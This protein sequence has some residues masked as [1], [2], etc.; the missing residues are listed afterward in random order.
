[1]AI[2]FSGQKLFTTTNNSVVLANQSRASVALKLRFE[3][4]GNPAHSNLSFLISRNFYS[5][6]WISLNGAG[7][8][9]GTVK[10]QFAWRTSATQVTRNVDLAVGVVHHLAMTFD[11]G[12]QVCWVNGKPQSFGSL[13]GTTQTSSSPFRIGGW[14][15]TPATDSIWT[16][17]DVAV[18]NDYVLTASDVAN[19]RDGVQSPADIG[20][21]ATMRGEWTLL[22]T[23]GQT[24]V[25]GQPGL[26]NAFG[27][28]SYDLTSITGSGTAV[29]ADPLVWTPAA[30]VKEARIGTSGKTLF[31]FFENTATGQGAIPQ[32]ANVA[33]AIVKNGGSLGQ[34][35]NPLCSGV[36]KYVMYTLPPGT[37]VAPGDVVTLNA[38]IDWVTTAV[39]AAGAVSGL[40]VVNNAGRSCFTS[41]TSGR[42]L[43]MGVNVEWY[44]T[45]HNALIPFAK[46]IAKRNNGFTGVA[47][48]DARGKPI[49]L[50]STWASALLYSN[51]VSTLDNG[52]DAT[53]YPGPTGLFAVGWDD[54][55]P[56]VPTTFGLASGDSSTTTVTERVD[57]ANPG[58]GGIG[59][60][61][62]FDVQRKAGSTVAVT[63]INLTVSNAA[64]A[65][66][67]DN[68]VVYGPGDFSYSSGKP[69]V[70]DRSN[71][72][73]LSSRFLDRI[74]RAGSLR[75]MANLLASADGSQIVEPEHVRELEDFSW[76]W[77]PSKSYTTIR[78]TR[79]DPF[80]VADT[81]YYYS[82]VAGGKYAATLADPIDATATTLNIS[83]AATAPVLVGLRLFVG[84][85]I[86]RVTGVSG[87]AVT[88]IRGAEGTT[89]APH[90]AGTI[91]VGYRL[92]MPA[93]NV[94]N[95]NGTF[96][97]FTTENPHGLSTGAKI[98]L[99]GS[100]WPI[101]NFTNGSATTAENP[102][103]KYSG[104][105]LVTGANTFVVR[106]GPYVT[107]EAT[108]TGVITLTPANN[109]SIIDI[110]GG[111]QIPY[112]FAALA[113]SQANVPNLFVNV[114]HM[115]T[116]DLVS[117]LARDVR[118]N[119]A[120]GKSLWVELSNEPWNFAI[121]NQYFKYISRSLY[122]GQDAMAYYVK[123]IDEVAAIFR[124]VFGEQGRSAEIK[125]LL[126]VQTVNTLG[127]S[128]LTWA[129]AQTPAIKIDGLAVAPYIEPTSNW[130][131]AASV[132]MFA[133]MDIEQ[134]LDLWI[135][136]QYYKTDNLGLTAFAAA[137][138]A[139]IDSYNTSTG[140]N[141]QL[142]SYEGGVQ[143]IYPSSVA[144]YKERDR[145]CVYHPN[146]YIIE[147]DWYYLLQSIGFKLFNVFAMS[148][149][150]YKGKYLW[151]LYHWMWQPYGRGD[152]SDGLPDNRLY[153]ATPGRP[154][155]KVATTN[156]D[157]QN[158]SVRGR[159][160]LD[161]NRSVPG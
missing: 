1:M 38:P 137:W 103:T 92:A 15:Y 73:A 46:N 61:R 139:A 83:D 82:R 158:V 157:L 161:W 93:L 148:H 133:N 124:S 153:Q 98:E 128:L 126:N 2:T 28:A 146:W 140:Y 7:S 29:Y 5:A 87:T 8:A 23:T 138:N 6:A 25:A 48:R 110:P 34:A 122:P 111:P 69:T 49:T 54:L 156:H 121:P 79:A 81:P 100:G 125:V 112:G 43:R 30:R 159:A 150:W 136:N 36:H 101:F 52:I 47:A 88:V 11:Q 116:N 76:G 154:S 64:N 63:D 99:K 144:N 41:G 27:N 155:S 55:N 95:N 113:A 152:G 118:D 151:G 45:G 20:A 143:L 97:K 72:Y 127:A 66:Q 107:P 39:G 12:S 14:D 33:P 84:S 35:V 16:I 9:T 119:L 142:I 67:F 141:C 96:V 58:T 132:A 19:L 135:H 94:V 56:S 129:A 108:L 114:P 32:S 71:P 62:V 3:S 102:I 115:A 21:T 22:G 60:V 130:F 145:D 18:W 120:P 51:P 117:K 89:P 74:A 149:D 134:A 75:F 65:P 59:K 4:E 70:L 104:A 86:M 26:A 90:A 105:A 147:T 85:E 37:S 42:W 10:L 57:L 31:V 17:D 80:S 106:L 91:Q 123:R 44:P 53:G 160:W 68:L 77:G 40:P 24:P 50:T 131:D 109:Y 13:S 78:Y